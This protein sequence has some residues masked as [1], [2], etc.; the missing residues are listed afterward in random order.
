MVASMSILILVNFG[1]V[2][3]FGGN[4]IYLILLK[5][6]RIVRRYFDP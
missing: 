6:Y 2:V 1:F 5:Y 3:Y 4:D